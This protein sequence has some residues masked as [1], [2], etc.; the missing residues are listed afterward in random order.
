MIDL[1]SIENNKVVFR[2][3]VLAIKEFLILWRRDRTKDKKKVFKEMS[4]IF[5][6]EDLRSPFNMYPEDERS[7]RIIES[8]FKDEWT[9]DRSVKAAQERYR[10]LTNTRSMMLLKDTWVT[11]DKLGEY[12]RSMDLN[13]PK[14]AAS[15][16]GVVKDMP[17]L[18][19]SLKKLEDEVRKELDSK[20]VLRGGRDKGLFEDPLKS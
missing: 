13:S 1:F 10:G 9:P 17:S 16:K 5:Y 19:Q 14:D 3:E 7:D 15:I 20:G 18:V 6:S 4:F 12:L 11:M 8:V 2:P